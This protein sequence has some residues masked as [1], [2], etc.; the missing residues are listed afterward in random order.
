MPG[1]VH[2]LHT[3]QDPPSGPSAAITWGCAAFMVLCGL[4]VTAAGLA[5]VISVLQ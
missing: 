4:G 2:E 1:D 5:A 3:R